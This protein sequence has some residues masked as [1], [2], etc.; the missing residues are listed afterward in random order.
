[1]T[2]LQRILDNYRKLSQKEIVKRQLAFME[3]GFDL[4]GNLTKERDELHKR[5]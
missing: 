4:G 2:D 1:M 3:K 5:D